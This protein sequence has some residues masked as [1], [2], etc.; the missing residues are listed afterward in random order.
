MAPYLPDPFDQEK[1]L[2]PTSIIFG[3]AIIQLSVSG[4]L[5]EI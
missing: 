5:F 3:P 4:Q 1:N 2:A